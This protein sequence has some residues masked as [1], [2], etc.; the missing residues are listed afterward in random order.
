MPEKHSFSL[1]PSIRRASIQ[2]FDIEI[3]EGYTTEN[4]KFVARK[5]SKSLILNYFQLESYFTADS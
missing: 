5:F 3:G 1:K 2:A 4:V